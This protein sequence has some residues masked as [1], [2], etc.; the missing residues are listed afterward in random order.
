[1]L[2]HEIRELHCI[3]QAIMLSCMTNADRHK[4]QS[5]LISINYHQSVLITIKQYQSAYLIKY[6]P[7]VS[8]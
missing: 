1:M 7:V 4:Y 2:M 6:G 3:I 8:Y 5:V